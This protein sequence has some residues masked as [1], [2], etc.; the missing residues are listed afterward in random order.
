[1]NQLLNGFIL[2]PDTRTTPRECTLWTT[3]QITLWS[4]L[5]TDN[6]IVNPKRL[7]TQFPFI[8]EQT[9]GVLWW[10]PRRRTGWNLNI[11]ITIRPCKWMTASWTLSPLGQL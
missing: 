4:T 6:Q 3:L 10:Q 7:V 5:R 8:T 2:I 9:D 11:F 1:M